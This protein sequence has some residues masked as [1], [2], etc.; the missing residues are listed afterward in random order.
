MKLYRRL[1]VCFLFGVASISFVSGAIHTSVDLD[2]PVYQI[3][4]VAQI[5]GLIE[6]QIAVKPYSAHTVMNLLEQIAA[7]ETKISKN[8]VDEVSRLLSELEITHGRRNSGLNN[9]FS[10]GYLSSFDQEKELGAAFGITVQSQQTVSLQTKEYDSRNEIVAF[11]KGDIG[12]NA[13]FNMDFGIVVDKL[14]HN[15]FLPTEFTIPGEGFYMNLFDGGSTPRRVPFPSFYS[16]LTL[17]P[18]LAISLIDSK[19]LLRWASIKRNWGPGLENLMISKDARSF[20]AI[21]I[22]FSFTSWLRYSVISGSLGK[23]SLKD[24]DGQPFFSDYFGGTKEDKKHY[25]F[26]N[27]YNAHRVELDATKDITLAVYEAVVWQK[28]SELGY[29][30]PFAIYMFQQNNLGDIDNMFA[31]LDITYTLASRF[32]LYGSVAVSEMNVVGNPIKMLKA[33]RNMFAFQAGIVIPIPIGN[34]SSFTFQWTHI[35]PFVY[36]HYPMRQYTGY[37][38]DV[39]NSETITSQERKVTLSGNKITLA[40]TSKFPEQVIDVSDGDGPWFTDDGRA[41]VSLKEDRYHIYETYAETTFVNKGENIGY[42][43]DPN[44]QE[45]LAQLDLG[46]DQGWRAQLQTKY[47]VRSGQYGYRIEQFMDYRNDHL[48][49]EKDFWAHTF[50]HILAIKLE[51]AKKM[52]TMPISVTASYRFISNW[53]RPIINQDEIGYDG[54]GTEFGAWQE[55]RINHVAQVG[56]KIFH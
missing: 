8:E 44:S 3:L 9:L 34:F 49:P 15:V 56:V 43:L 32:R 17:S 10:T 28:R 46:F 40:A 39:D 21:D 20:D 38:D 48:Y 50:S 31:G 25:R 6:R 33:P 16:S 30:N 24:I 36:A 51:V 41:M 54:R 14:N 5:R 2:H 37:V 22:Q 35:S 52:Q 42:P 26:E 29:L 4:E 19:V 23:F 45:F 27:N 12:P 1:L 53:S 47:Q 18:E 13:S 11:M 7:Q 55:A